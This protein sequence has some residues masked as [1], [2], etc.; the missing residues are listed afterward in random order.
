MSLHAVPPEDRANRYFGYDIPTLD[1]IHRINGYGDHS[2]T[3]IPVVIIGAG[4]SGI[5]MAYKL[6]HRLGFDQFKL[7]DRQSGIGGTWWINRYPGVAC[8]VP[9][10]FYSFSFSPNPKWTAFYPTGPEIY[11]YLEDVCNKF[12]LVDKIELDTDVVS[13]RWISSEEVWEVNLQHLVRGTG[14]LSSV[15]R[16]KRIGELGDFSVYTARE[17]VRCKVLISAVGGLVSSRH[18]HNKITPVDS[19]RW[20]LNHLIMSQELR[21]L[22]V[23]YFT[24]LAGIIL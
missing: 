4:E 7:F 2:Y 22:K 10:V 18:V 12:G 23:P 19:H 6:K 24:L 20:N 5:C 3:Y 17:T 1:R 14:D 16:E 9:A 13:C 21:R 11:A 8:D 15:D